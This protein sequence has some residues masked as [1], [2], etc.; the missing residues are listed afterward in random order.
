MFPRRIKMI[1]IRFRM[2]SRAPRR[3]HHPLQCGQLP[4]EPG[5]QV[6]RQSHLPGRG[7]ATLNWSGSD[8]HLADASDG[9][10]VTGLT[11]VGAGLN[12]INNTYH[13]SNCTFRNMN[14]NG[15][16]VIDTD[17]G[18]TIDHNTFTDIRGDA[19]IMGNG[20]QNT[21]VSYNRFDNVREGIHFTWGGTRNGADNVS[22]QHNVFTHVTHFALE[23]QGN[24]NGLDIGYNWVDNWVPDIS[25]IGFSIATGGVDGNAPQSPWNTSLNVKVHDNVI[26][27]NN[28]SSD[29]FSHFY[30]YSAIEAMGTD[31][32]IYNNFISGGWSDS[33][34]YTFTTPAWSYHDNTTVGVVMGPVADAPSDKAVAPASQNVYNNT[35][36]PSGARATPGMPNDAGRNTSS[37]PSPT[38]TP[39]PTPSPTPTPTPTPS[40]TPSGSSTYL[41]DVNPTS[42][43]NGHGPYERDMSNGEQ[44]TGD[45]HT[46]SLNGVTYSKGLGVHAGSD[47]TYSLN[48]QFKTFSAVVGV[49]DEVNGDGSVDFQVYTDN[50]VKLYDS[51]VM[52]GANAGKAINL[53]VSGKQS[54][55]LVVTD[56]GDG[57][58]YDHADWADARVSRTSGS[59]PTSTPSP[60]P[61]PT[62][63]PTPSPTPT[64]TPTGS[65]TFLSDV[66]P[67]S[68]TNGHG[69][70][71]RDMSNGEQ[72][73][74]D[75]QTLRMNGVTY[76]KGLG[77]HANSDISYTLGGK[78]KT[79]SAAIGID[80]ETNN[81][82]SVDFQVFTDNGQK[83]YDSGVMNGFSA[84]KIV[85]VDVSGK[86]TLRLVVTDA[87]DGNAYDHAD[88]ANARV[89]ATARDVNADADA[90]AHA[91][92]DS[93]LH[94]GRHVPR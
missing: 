93:H 74:G 35:M 55:R 50:G 48:G 36:L 38:P 22:I 88:W 94:R 85:N 27:G 51:G 53:D 59:T 86:Q 16:W 67:A 72:Y 31:I 37:S 49:D 87:G 23:Q 18:S 60:T 63:T 47:I 4:R 46:I 45:G 68:A 15:I 13:V 64:P 83:L 84:T 58:A 25:Q 26:G 42:A 41:S 1:P 82:G 78:Y 21:S 56:G 71:E 39:T 70:Y 52:R 34:M 76:S 65:G 89:S 57:N 28:L 14:G 80:D 66:N 20:L 11:F 91:H 92:A 61:S 2:L 7:G 77:V 32:A 69:P 19:A 75:G 54:L 81:S 12:I 9:A 43:T 73:A 62:P 6:P 29:N 30:Y 10:T 3:G 90:D 17:G 79:F 44:F 33:V 8:D 24:P 40:V 5:P